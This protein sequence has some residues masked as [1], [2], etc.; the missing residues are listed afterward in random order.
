M[1]NKKSEIIIGIDPGTSLTAYSIVEVKYN[2]LNKVLYKDKIDN[3]DIYN[4]ILLA[5]ND[6]LTFEKTQSCDINIAIEHMESHGM[7]VGMTT[8][9]TCYFI[10]EL[11]Y[12][13]SHELYRD[14]KSNVSTDININLYRV[15]RS[16]EKN[17][18]CNSVRAKDSNIRQ[19][20]IDRFGEVG[21]K[22]N[23]GYFYG[24]KADIWAS[25]AIA[26][27]YYLMTL[28]NAKTY[29]NA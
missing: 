5:L 17:Y 16:Q 3:Q 6:Y 14:I 20:L 13:L 25:F 29:K 18:I 15:Y 28:N 23:Q 10:G 8:F 1:K 27:T 12:K 19:A 11:K 21:T 26:Y 24:F 22:N 9:E 7:A 4:A 2:T